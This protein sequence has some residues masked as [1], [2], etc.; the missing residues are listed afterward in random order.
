MPDEKKKTMT[1]RLQFCISVLLF[2]F[3]AVMTGGL[4]SCKSAQTD[5]VFYRIPLEQLEQDYQHF[6][7]DSDLRR[8]YFKK[9]DKES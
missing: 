4:L 2:T 8:I 3:I 9:G 6:R 7:V 1:S 5:S